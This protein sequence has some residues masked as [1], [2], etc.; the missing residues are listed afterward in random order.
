MSLRCA[1]RLLP[2]L[3]ACALAFATAATPAPA[4]PTDPA[5]LLLRLPD[6][7][8]GYG[9]THINR[10][11]TVLETSSSGFRRILGT[12]T[13]RG[14][15][16]S[17]EQVWAP[18][19]AAPGP[20][21]VQSYAFTF[22]T[23]AGPTAALSR[24]RALA[25]PFP[26]RDL[27]IVEPAPPIGD[28]AVVMRFHKTVLGLHAS[29]GIVVWR[30]GSVLGMVMAAS[31]TRGEAN[32][33]AAVRLATLQQARIA[34]PTPL[35]P[36][37]NDDRLVPLDDPTLG[38]PV[39]WL[40]ERLPARSRFPALDLR[41]TGETFGFGGGPQ[42]LALLL[43][44]TRRIPEAA[45]VELWRPRD[46]RRDFRRSPHPYQCRRRFDIDVSGARAWIVATLRREPR[47]ASGRCPHGDASLT[48][49]AFFNDVAVKIDASR[50][51]RSHPD[52]Y[53]S[54]AGLRTLLRALR[55]REPSA[56]VTP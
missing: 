26:R 39:M 48:A 38:V 11:C 35:R 15:W 3:A 24:P 10:S 29:A 33:R 18:P 45:N 52:P 9:L 56:P 12:G 46:L 23:P 6:L 49:V 5:P 2:A 31:L 20:G 42:R 4:A 32:V 36:P 19:G 53:N 54:R 51:C 44:R 43:Y 22:D 21:G 27:R 55:L 50:C 14:C 40:G 37:V 7:G 25:A 13:S 8:P 28:Q 17:F 34:N 30:S 41:A 47:R 16:L 1:C